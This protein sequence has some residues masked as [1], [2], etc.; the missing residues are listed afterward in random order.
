MSSEEGRGPGTADGK[1]GGANSCDDIAHRCLLEMQVFNDTSAA[2]DVWLGPRVAPH[3]ATPVWQEALAHGAS[4]PASALGRRSG[5]CTFCS[6]SQ[7]PLGQFMPFCMEVLMFNQNWWI[8]GHAGHVGKGKVR[9]LILEVDLT[10]PHMSQLEE[11][12]S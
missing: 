2:L 12:M 11:Y 3:A 1:P 7:K 4:L 9:M 6:A 10:C 5:L 8:L